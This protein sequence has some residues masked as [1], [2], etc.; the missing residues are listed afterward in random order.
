[1]DRLEKFLEELAELSN[2]YKFKIAGCGC[3]G[4]PYLIDDEDEY[5]VEDLGFLRETGK[6]DVGGRR[7]CS[8]CGY[9]T[10]IKDDCC[11]TCGAK[12]KEGEKQ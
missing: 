7:K 3:C 11:S 1:M 12:M 2:K 9:Y 6:Y 8:C 10:D 5:D 4:S